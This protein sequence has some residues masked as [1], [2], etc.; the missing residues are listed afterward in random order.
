MKTKIAITTDSAADIGK[1]AAKEYDIHVIPMNILVSESQFKDGIDITVRQMLKKCEESKSIPKATAVSAQ[2]YK[3]VFSSL[4]EKG[5]DVIHICPSSKLFPCFENASFAANSFDNVHVIDSLTVS[6]GLGLL[7]L[8]ASRMR[9]EEK[10]ADEIVSGIEA[11]KTQI[12]TSF[13]V[14]NTDL[15]YKSGKCTALDKT[16][17]QL[18]GFYPCVEIKDGVMSVSEKH[19]GSLEAARKKYL[20]QRLECLSE[21]GSESL[22]L[23]SCENGKEENDN[24][25]SFIKE[26]S[27]AKFVSVSEGGCCIA[28]YCSAG[29][30]GLSFKRQL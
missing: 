20:S 16:G 9:L 1:P 7:C 15:L 21:A 6:A 28:S 18:F 27:P 25:C 13:L 5:Y 8:E 12:D 29:F 2:E 23:S 11:L 3:L 30:I 10:T 14:E 26:I 4:V 24:L 19:K 17:A 22:I